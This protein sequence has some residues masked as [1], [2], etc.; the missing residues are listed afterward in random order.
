MGQKNG[1]RFQKENVDKNLSS[2]CREKQPNVFF[3]GIY[4]KMGFWHF[5]P[6][7]RLV[8]SPVLS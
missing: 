1:S 7:P 4:P 8:S 6:S 3:P 5:L 2:S